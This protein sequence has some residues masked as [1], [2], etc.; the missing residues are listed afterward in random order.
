MAF[1]TLDDIKSWLGIDL[2][3]TKYDSTLTIIRD[4]V[5]TSV[6]E[7][8]ENNFE[9]N[10]VQE[11]RDSN[12]SDVIVPDNAPIDSVTAVYFNVNTDGTGGSLIDPENYQV[13]ENKIHLR[14]VIS[15]RGRS[16][17][18][19]DY[20]YGYNGVPADVKHAILLSVDA[21]FRRK[22]RKDIGTVSRSKKD[23]SETFRSSTSGWDSK[24]GLPKEAVFKL[25]PYRVFEFPTQPIATRNR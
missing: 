22:G 1:C 5:E 8:T 17:V 4:S 25:N 23:E 15:P 11:V 21:E 19:V 16:T 12:Q 13:R 24:T 10:S 20:T 2:A 6:I 9:L 14:G 18:R 3:E 7:Y